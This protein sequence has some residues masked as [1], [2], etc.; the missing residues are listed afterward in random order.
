MSIRKPDV[1]DWLGIEKGTG[2]IQLTIVDDED[3]A[4]E[5]EHLALLETKLDRYLALIACS[6]ARARSKREATNPEL[7]EKPP[8]FRGNAV[9]RRSLRALR[10]SYDT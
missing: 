2:D 5:D 4:D 3:W 6:A 7:L 1:V 10:W 8:V 9:W